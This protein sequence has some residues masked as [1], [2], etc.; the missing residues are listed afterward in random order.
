MFVLLIL[1]LLVGCVIVVP[2]L[3]L[4]LVLHLVLGLALIPLRLAGLVLRLALG[5]AGMVLA[6][7]L[8]LIVPLLPILALGGAV[9]WLV[10]LAGGGRRAHAPAGT[11]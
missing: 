10:R 9:W 7:A 11:V 6:A 2:L 8:I 4:W 5:L 3:L 1:C